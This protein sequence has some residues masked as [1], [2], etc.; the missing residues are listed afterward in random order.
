MT[1]CRWD[2]NVKPFNLAA[3]KIGDFT[4]KIIVA[5]F[6]LANSN[7]ATSS[8]SQYHR[9][10]QCRTHYR[11]YDPSADDIQQMVAIFPLCPDVRQLLILERFNHTLTLPI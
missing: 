10:Q 11:R 5:P 9:Y 3:L 7:H 8:N 2:S 6:V 1:L 4:C